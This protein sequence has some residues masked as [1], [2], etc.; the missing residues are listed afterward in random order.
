MTTS[1]PRPK[2]EAEALGLAPAI[3]AW[4]SKDLNGVRNNIIEKLNELSINISTELCAPIVG[5]AHEAELRIKLW[6]E[7]EAR[8]TAHQ[9]RCEQVLADDLRHRLAD[10]ILFAQGFDPTQLGEPERVLL[11]GHLATDFVFDFDKNVV[12]HGDHRYLAVLVS[13]RPLAQ[14][15]ARGRTGAMPTVAPISDMSDKD[16][17]ELLEEHARRVVEEDAEPLIS[18]SRISYAPILR[19]KMR[20][21]AGR[22]ELHATLA[23]E[24]RYLAGWIG[25]KVPS[26]Q[27]PTAP[28]LEN[29]LRTTYNELKA[30][31]KGM[32][33]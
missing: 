22:G 26:H 21:R 28:S 13:Q 30:Q 20:F 3:R 27:T 23:A 1:Q 15:A 11:P 18:P 6:T 17:F 31:S 8:L 12:E 9:M 16:L 29:A 7:Q 5:P 14:P 32:K 24:A 10:K 4:C 25:E 2:D 19:R 33:A